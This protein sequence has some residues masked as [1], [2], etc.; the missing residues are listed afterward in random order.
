[1]E[2]PRCLVCTDCLAIESPRS[3]EAIVK[4][5]LPRIASAIVVHRQAHESGVCRILDSLSWVIGQGLAA[6]PV[7]H[8]GAWSAYRQVSEH[9]EF[10]K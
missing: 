1:M 2:E 3:E 7:S 10:A 8:V 4:K 9:Y 5:R 6:V